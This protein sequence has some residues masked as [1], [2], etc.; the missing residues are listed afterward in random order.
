MAYTTLYFTVRH[1]IYS[2]ITIR[3]KIRRVDFNRDFIG[4][5]KTLPAPRFEPGTFQL[6]FT[7][8]EQSVA[9]DLF[10]SLTVGPQLVA[11]ALGT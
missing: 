8:A 11:G 5:R 10:R 2:N 6:C 7:L 9:F 4:K 3:V 1:F